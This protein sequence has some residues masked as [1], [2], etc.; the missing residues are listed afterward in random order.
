M[1][2]SSTSSIQ[3]VRKLLLD[4]VICIELRGGRKVITLLELLDLYLETVSQM[5]SET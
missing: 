3:I 4:L 2:M 5:G 1:L